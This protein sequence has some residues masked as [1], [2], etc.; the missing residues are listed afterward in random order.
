MSITAKET[1]VDH[2]TRLQNARPKTA[3]LHSAGSSDVPIED[4]YVRVSFVMEIM[5]VATTMTKAGLDVHTSF[6]RVT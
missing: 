3:A 6:A 5:I 1:K 4:T 2:I